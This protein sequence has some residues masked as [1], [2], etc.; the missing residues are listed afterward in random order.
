[1]HLVEN[2]GSSLNNELG[3]HFVAGYFS[4]DGFLIILPGDNTNEVILTV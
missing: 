3:V 4:S 1:M 2:M